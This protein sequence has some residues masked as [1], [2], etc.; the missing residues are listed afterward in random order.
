MARF[1]HV[2]VMAVLFGACA[3]GRPGARSP[4]N[5]RPIAT[6][7]SISLDGRTVEA[8]NDGSTRIVGRGPETFRIVATTKI[9]RYPDPGEALIAILT[10]G[11]RVV[12]QA[13]FVIDGFHAR[14]RLDVPSTGTYRL[15]LWSRQRFVAGNTF[16]AA[17]LPMLDGQRVLEL[18]QDAGPQLALTKEGGQIRW[19]HWDSLESDTAFVA[20]WWKDGKRVGAAG[21]KRSEFQREILAR[22]Q[23]T[24]Q[25]DGFA[26][27]PTW[28]WTREQFDLHDQ[29][30]AGH[31]ELRVYRD[32]HPALSFGFEV[33][34]DGS[35]R[36]AG[37]RTIHTGKVELDVSA[38]AASRDAARQLA[39][40][41]RT[42][43][44]PAKKSLLPV[45]VAEARALTRSEV[46]RSL[47]PRLNSL[48]RQASGDAVTT[49]AP[50]SA[51]AHKVAATMQ[52][53]ISSLGEPWMESERP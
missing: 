39:K 43:F 12:K 24:A 3:P 46:L 18:H 10:S 50:D 5:E 49:D 31:W 53:L 2:V 34:A 8:L 35:V 1:A 45:S 25:V 47:R 7:L 19:M 27:Q 48:Q 13:P 22:L 41:P 28:R 17:S 42:R 51:E 40:L 14:A 37:R 9:E 23:V 20:E 33:T 52:R 30:T 44:E 21:G 11:D 26:N 6:G 36:G 15:E 38:A 29:L 16:V 4:E 32:D